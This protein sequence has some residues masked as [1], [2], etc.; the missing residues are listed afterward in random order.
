MIEKTK[1]IVHNGASHFDEFLA[2]ALIMGKFYGLDFV[3]E[4]KNPSE[5]ELEDPNIWCVDVGGRY[6]PQKLNFDHHQDLRLPAAFGLVAKHFNIHKDMR[7]SHNWWE[8]H[9]VMDRKGPFE[10]SSRLGIDYKTLLCVTNPFVGFMLRKFAENPNSSSIKELMKD[11]GYSLIKNLEREKSMFAYFNRCETIKLNDKHTFVLNPSKDYFG[12]EKWIETQP[13]KISI[14]VS[15]DDRG[16]GWVFMRMRNNLGV[17][18]T[19]I[20]SDPRMLFVHKTGFIGKTKTLISIEQVKE[21]LLKSITM[22]VV[23]NSGLASS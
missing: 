13:T 16:E 8:V 22:E 20:S 1:I 21:L 3:I 5:A 19:K 2:I 10:V 11:F 4:R 6:E 23:C 15:Y 14:M 17:D 7:K 18:F 12:A 9:S